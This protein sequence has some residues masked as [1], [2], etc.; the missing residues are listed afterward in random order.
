MLI[1]NMAE[2]CAMGAQ[3]AIHQQKG[4]EAVQPRP[5]ATVQDD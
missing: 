1:F 4:D 2:Q 3:S 5:F